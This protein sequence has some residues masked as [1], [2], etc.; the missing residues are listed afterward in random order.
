MATIVANWKMYQPYDKAIAFVRDHK[1]ELE[2]LLHPYSTLV[3]APSFVCLD[4]M[5]QMLRDS[6]IQLCAQDVSA[7]TSGAYT[8]E[9]S[10]ASLADVG[11]YY[12][13]IGHSE[14]R[15]Y[16]GETNEMISQ[17]IQRLFENYITP[18]ICIGES[19]EDYKKG[20]TRQVLEAQ[21]AALMPAL[22]NQEE[23]FCIAYEP[24][25]AI[26]TGVTPDLEELEKILS[27][28]S[29][30]VHENEH[31]DIHVSM[32]LLYGG[33]VD[34]TNAAGFMTVPGLGGLLI[35]GASR[36][37]QTLKKIVSLT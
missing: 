28:I 12:A 34:E 18:I 15:R 1:Q 14:R 8:G 35:G 21:L 17:K 25:W 33:S 27:W 19:K 5:W 23:F 4:P 22:G 24:E 10:A 20:I 3:I 29:E 2:Q 36:D 16:F 11:C 30:F 26:G 9:V 31:D 6:R 32:G 37:F 7:Y 13:I